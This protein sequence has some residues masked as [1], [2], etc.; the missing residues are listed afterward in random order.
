MLN[1]RP[2][3]SPSEPEPACE[4][5]AELGAELRAA[6]GRRGGD[7]AEIAEALRIKPGYLEAFERGDVAALPSGPY[8]LGFLKA[9]ALHLELDPAPLVAR[10]KAARR[11]AATP[12][13]A[14][15]AAPIEGRRPAV[16]ML[17]ASLLLVGGIYGGY[18]LID[19]GA[20]P[21]VEL[22]ALP[23]ELPPEP[24][25]AAPIQPPQ[26]TVAPAAPPTAT[27]PVPAG[28][29]TSAL[30]AERVEPAPPPIRVAALDV[31]SA[32]PADLAEVAVAGRV[33]LLAR[34]SS[35]VQVRSAA[36]DYVRTRT[37]QPG[38]QFVLP[39][40]ADLA[41]WTGNAGGLELLLDG[42]SLGRAGALGAVV[43]DLSLAPD[44]LQR[45]QPGTAPATLP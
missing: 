45:P 43:R 17:V 10:L 14:P 28:D 23:P 40:R 27:G 1:R 34:E 15:H 39:D 20:P 13:L 26:L 33:V 12:V 35:W 25:V 44:S 5:L 21:P 24:R 2:K 4:T 7:L 31:D 37:M 6:R 32:P 30:A 19:G 36:R 3:T 11:P 42:Q 18:R 29:V 9:Y 38:E 41:L 22:V 16:A 8:A